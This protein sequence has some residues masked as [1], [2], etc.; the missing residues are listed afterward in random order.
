[1]LEQAKQQSA[2]RRGRRR[3]AFVL[4][5]TMMPVLDGTEAAEVWRD[6]E[7]RMGLPRAFL[8]T[9]SAYGEGRASEHVDAVL[10]KPLLFGDL[11]AVFDRYKSQN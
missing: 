8:V 2:E 5:D 6:L 1:L 9:V 10:K 7:R 3:G 11:R 4:L